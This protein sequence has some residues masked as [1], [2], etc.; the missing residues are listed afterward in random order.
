[1]RRPWLIP[2]L[3]ACAC[4]AVAQETSL[5]P[6]LPS[7]GPQFVHFLGATTVRVSSSSPAPVE[8]RFEV[9]RGDHINS[10]KVSSELLIPTRLKLSPA[11]DINIGRV[12]YPAGHDYSFSFAPEEKLNVYTGPFVINALVTATSQAYPGNYAVHGE[13]QYQACN[14]RACYPPKKLPIMFPVKVVRS[15]GSG[16]RNPRQSPHVHR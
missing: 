5:E 3:L 9:V 2:I 15:A 6:R 13:L 16:H 10:N 1:M 8:L 11:T 14:N 4:F 12:R 7:D